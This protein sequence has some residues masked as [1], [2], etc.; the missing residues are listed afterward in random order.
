[1]TS[2]EDSWR[3]TNIFTL[4]D[5]KGSSIETSATLERVDP[6]TKFLGL[7]DLEI[8]N[9]IQFSIFRSP[10]NYV[11]GK[12]PWGRSLLIG[13]G[14]SFVVRRVPYDPA[15]H[16][17]AL[18]GDPWEPRYS[19]FVVY[20]QPLLTNI[21]PVNDEDTDRLQAVLTEMK[22]LYHPPIRRH[23]NIVKLLQLRWDT[24]NGP[25]LIAPTLVLEHGDLGSLSA[26]QDQNRVVLHSRAKTQICL[27]VAE[28]LQ[29]LHD[30]GIVH[31]DVKSEYVEEFLRC[32]LF[33]A[34]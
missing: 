26:F 8:L 10:G 4:N 24:Q 29:F 21:N 17:V 6:F 9:A 15:E 7:I 28:G 25:N 3:R 22:V 12:A 13:H 18:W 31:G 2:I 32:S 5:V 19:K 1:M 33:R 11:G 14:S 30:C 27:D 34:N 20:K 16:S 23:P